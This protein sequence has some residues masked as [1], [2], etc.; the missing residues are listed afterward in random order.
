MQE[1][2]HQHEKESNMGSVLFAFAIGGLIGAGV[3]LLMAPRSGEETRM[4]IQEKSQ[5]LTDKAAHTLEETRNQAEKTIDD[6]A[7]Q[8]RERAEELRARGQDKLE[9]QK[10]RLD[11]KIR[12]NR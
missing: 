4:I 6:L 1:Y 2:M 8:T 10:A 9:E 3:A 7:H 12:A 11:E 5:E